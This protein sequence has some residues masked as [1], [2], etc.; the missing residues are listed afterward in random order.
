M[1]RLALVVDYLVGIFQQDSR[2][3]HEQQMMTFEGQPPGSSNDIVLKTERRG[4][5]QN[6]FV[7]TTQR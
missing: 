7:V 6:V 4:N 5:C 1:Q 3:L 2:C